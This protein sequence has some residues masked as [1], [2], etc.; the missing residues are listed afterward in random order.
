MTIDQRLLE[1]LAC[2]KCHGDLLYF[3]ADGNLFCAADG[4]QF[5][6]RDE[7]PVLLIDEATQV[8]AE[9]TQRL[10]EKARS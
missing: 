5:P 9:E 2:P 7:I 3:E 1:I 8:D 10:V 4:L 6:I